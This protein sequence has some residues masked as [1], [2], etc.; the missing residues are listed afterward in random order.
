VILLSSCNGMNKS[1]NWKT[2][3]FSPC[4]Q[5][6]ICLDPKFAEFREGPPVQQ[7]QFLQIERLALGTSLSPKHH[8]FWKGTKKSAR[9][10]CCDIERLSEKDVRNCVRSGN[11][12][13]L[14]TVENEG[15][16]SLP[17]SPCLDN[18]SKHV[19]ITRAPK[20]YPTSVTGLHKQIKRRVSV[21]VLP[22][23]TMQLQLWY[24]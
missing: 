5:I 20:A 9:G 11:D 21:S 2:W 10:E 19:N 18:S 13:D 15:F 16:K 22:S 7:F 8:S 24:S 6:P 1:E 23:D 17:A 12:L 4:E 3:L 14:T